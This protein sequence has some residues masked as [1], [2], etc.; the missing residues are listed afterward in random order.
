MNSTIEFRDAVI[1]MLASDLSL[2]AAGALVAYSDGLPMTVR[3][4]AIVTAVT[5]YSAAAGLLALA[6]VNVVMGWRKLR[7]G[8][9]D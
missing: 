4:A 5:F 6:G 2:A 1:M 7:G 8:D 9:H 3:A